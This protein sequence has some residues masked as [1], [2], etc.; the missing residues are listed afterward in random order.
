ML[1]VNQLRVVRDQWQCLFDFTLPEGEIWSIAG[2]SGAGKSTLLDVLAGFVTAN[3]GE[4]R[5]HG[6]S[7]LSLAPHQRPV[8]MLFQQ[9]NV[10][11]HLR[12]AQNLALG[13]TAKK[14]LTPAQQAQLEEM[15]E[16]LEIADYLAKPCTELSGGQ[17]Q[18]VA[19][20]RAL[21]MQRPI[22][23]LDEPFSALD[24]GTRQTMQRLVTSIHQEFKLTTLLVSHQPEELT[25]MVDRQ[26]TV[27]AG[28]AYLD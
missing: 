25:E 13:L 22:L 12:V 6:Q 15:A 21:L 8:T 23:L 19:L 26:L 24:R 10:F 14:R 4:A 11:E 7:L 17:Q 16:R 9:N 2:P 18:R 5:F 20:G 3:E 1:E 28:Q 27:T